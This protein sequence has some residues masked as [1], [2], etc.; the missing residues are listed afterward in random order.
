M[1]SDYSADAAYPLGFA[2]HG[3]GRTHAQCQAG[4]CNA[5]FFEGVL[6]LVQDELCRDFFLSQNGCSSTTTPD[7][8]SVHAEIQAS[9]DIDETNQKCVDYQGCDAGYPVRWCEHSEGGYR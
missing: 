7:L 1:P 8:A 2:F 9:R 3:F 6:D 4:D 5:D